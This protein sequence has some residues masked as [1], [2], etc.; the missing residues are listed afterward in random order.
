MLAL[1]FAPMRTLLL[2]TCVQRRSQKNE[3]LNWSS[4]TGEACEP[5]RSL[6]LVTD[7][8][9]SKFGSLNG[10][11]SISSYI[12][13]IHV[14]ILLKRTSECLR[15]IA[16]AANH[17]LTQPPTIYSQENLTCPACK[18]PKRP[19]ACNCSKTHECLYHPRL[20]IPQILFS[21]NGCRS[22]IWQKSSLLW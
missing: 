20:E 18:G 5:H 3:R 1:L 16:V 4:S 15:Y 9:C 7:S 19:E 22:K 10:Y 13:C 11:G 2:R 21:A 14:F 6:V 8:G 17:L 12:F